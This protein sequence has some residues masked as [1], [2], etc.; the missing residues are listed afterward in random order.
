MLRRPDG[1]PHVGLIVVAA[2]CLA[3][4]WFE[5]DSG[6]AW[7]P[8]PEPVSLAT[9]ACPAEGVWLDEAGRPFIDG[10]ETILTTGSSLRA[11]AAGP[12][13]LTVV[14]R[15]SLA[16]GIGSRA[17]LMQGPHRLLDLELRDETAALDVT[18]PS[19][20]VMILAFINDLYEPPADRNLW[21]TELTFA[22]LSR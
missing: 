22:P 5:L 11:C 2:G 3:L 17:V 8:S 15:G 4:A 9:I 20:G 1:L 18:V 10:V 14:L 6:P 7:A 19:A 12:G 21:I 13:V 16:A